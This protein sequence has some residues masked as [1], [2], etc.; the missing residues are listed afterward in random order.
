MCPLISVPPALEESGGNGVE[1]CCDLRKIAAE[2]QRDRADMAAAHVVHAVR[3]EFFLRFRVHEQTR[4]IS[5]MLPVF[6][7]AC[8]SMSAKSGASMSCAPEST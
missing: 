2:I 7:K 1:L 6:A 8:D 5:G 4:H 3:Q